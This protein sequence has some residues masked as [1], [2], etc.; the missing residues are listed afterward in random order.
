MNPPHRE[1]SKTVVPLKIGVNRGILP[2]QSPESPHV[3]LKYVPQSG[4]QSTP[5]ARNTIW[6]LRPQQSSFSRQGGVMMNPVRH[7]ASL[8]C[9]VG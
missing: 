9:L 7:F 5:L 4:T 8:A 1:A 2:H 6:G 3:Y